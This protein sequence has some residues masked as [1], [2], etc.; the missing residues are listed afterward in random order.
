ML[1]KINKPQIFH[2]WLSKAWCEKAA[3]I[4]IALPG[5][6][7]AGAAGVLVALRSGLLFEFKDDPVAD[8][9]QHTIQATVERELHAGDARTSVVS[10]FARNNLEYDYDPS[11]MRYRAVAYRSTDGSHHVVLEIWV[12]DSGRFLSAETTDEQTFF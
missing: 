4:A 11:S 6:S 12:D 8:Q 7:A 2:W 9:T 3:L 5:F 1:S 10:F